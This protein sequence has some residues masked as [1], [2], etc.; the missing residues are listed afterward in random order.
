M[1]DQPQPTSCEAL[2]SSSWF[3]FYGGEATFILR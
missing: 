3:T 2:D 1:S